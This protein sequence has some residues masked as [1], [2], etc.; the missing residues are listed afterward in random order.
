[1]PSDLSSPQVPEATPFRCHILTL[2]PDFF[3][4]PLESSIVGRAIAARRLDVTLVDI[5]EHTTDKHRTTDDTPYGGG[6]GMVM[7]P[8]PVVRAIE[9]VEARAGRA[10]RVLLSPQGRPFRQRDAERLAREPNLMMLCGHYEGVDERVLS[11][12]IDEEIS[13]GDFVLT[14]GELGALVVLDALSRL[15]PG[16]LGNVDSAKNESFSDPRLL[17]HPHYTRPFDFRGHL[18]PEVLRSGDHQ[19]IETWR[20]RKSLLRTKTNRP[21][22]FEAIR[23]EISEVDLVAIAEMASENDD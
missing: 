10:H 19:R 18:V 15:L 22:L 1:M 14:G 5:R 7:K 4:S 6:A 23:P 21:D 8:E 16:V 3:R 2:F 11:H 12:Y 17:E 20:Y 13:I 9:F